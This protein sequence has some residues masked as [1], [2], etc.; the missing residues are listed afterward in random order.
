MR[1]WMK[2]L[3]EV[4][5]SVRILSSSR[6]DLNPAL[7]LRWSLEHNTSMNTWEKE[8]MMIKKK[9]IAGPKFRLW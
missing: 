4:G 5:G 2:D 1:V 6:H 3:R 9:K 8:S 7:L